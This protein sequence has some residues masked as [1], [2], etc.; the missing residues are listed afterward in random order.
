MMSKVYRGII[1]TSFGFRVGGFRVDN[2]DP[3]YDIVQALARIVEKRDQQDES[4][5]KTN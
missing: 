2:K 5:C 1:E 3:G 4:K